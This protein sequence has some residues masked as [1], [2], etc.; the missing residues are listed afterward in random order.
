LLA[1]VK[2]PLLQIENSSPTFNNHSDPPFKIQGKR[3]E[4]CIPF[5]KIFKRTALE[6]ELLNETNLNNA[7]K[8]SKVSAFLSLLP[9]AQVFVIANSG[10]R[11]RSDCVLL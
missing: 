3:V 4:N 9:L 7:A 2:I 10:A 6:N 11:Y 1:L 8:T 5:K